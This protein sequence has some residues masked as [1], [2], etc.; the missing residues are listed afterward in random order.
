[1][2]SAVILTKNEEQNIKAC[3]ESVSWCEEIVVIDDHSEDRTVDITKKAGAKV[4]IRDLN[5]N[6]AEQRNFGLEKAKGEWVLFVDADEIISSAL[7]YEIMAVTNDPANSY[8]GFFLKRRDTMWGK[9]MNHGE[10]GN[11]KLLRLAKKG[12]GLWTGKV[13]EVWKVT[14]KTMTLVNAVQH[15]PHPTIK[16]FLSE[17][18][19]YTTL[20]AQELFKRK[21]RVTWWGILFYPKAKFFMNYFV[22]LGFLDGLPGFVFALMMSFHSFLVRAKLWTIWQKA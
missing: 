2:I 16:E 14:G 11:I 6:F 4:F 15:Y 21:T 10:T 22:K 12:A 9:A 20:R 3:L 17:I 13:H 18:N 7:W 5:N 19:Y 1:M 8:E